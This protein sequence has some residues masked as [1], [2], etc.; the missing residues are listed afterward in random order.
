MNTFGSD[1]RKPT[2]GIDYGGQRVGLAVSVGFAPRPVDVLTHG[3]VESLIERMLAVASTEQV[4]RIVIGLPL[5]T[6]GTEGPQADVTR[7]FAKQLAAETSL[8]VMLWDERHTSQQAEEQMIAAGTSAKARREKL[9]AIAAALLLQDFF[10][11]D[12][13]GAERVTVEE[14][15]NQ[16]E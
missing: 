13:A 11:N 16:D 3:T 1:I 5:N 7:E 4:A 14:P 6:D 10:A 2:L 15:D 12:G 8:P 9:D